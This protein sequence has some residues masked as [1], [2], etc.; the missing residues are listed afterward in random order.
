MCLSGFAYFVI[1]FSDVQH[2]HDAIVHEASRRSHG[3]SKPHPP[4]RVWRCDCR[5]VSR[6]AHLCSLLRGTIPSTPRNWGVNH[7]DLQSEVQ[8]LGKALKPVGRVSVMSHR[9]THFTTESSSFLE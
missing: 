1:A 8:E 2:N 3:K 4:E 5:D 6:E 7:T 9:I